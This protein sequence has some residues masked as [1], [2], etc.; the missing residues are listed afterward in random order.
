VASV[1]PYANHLHLAPDRQPRQYL[2]THFLQTGCSSRRPANSVK[3]LKALRTTLKAD[4]HYPY[5]RP[6]RTGVK[7]ASCLYGPYVRV[8]RIGLNNSE[9]L[10]SAR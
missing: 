2:I 5:V 1:G 10:A 4:T 9:T 7:N 6:V 3:T 8:V